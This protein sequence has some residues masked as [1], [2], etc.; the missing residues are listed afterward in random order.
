[1]TDSPQHPDASAA[2]AR[3]SWLRSLQ[4][5]FAVLLVLLAALAV[6]PWLVSSLARQSVDGLAR[7]FDRAGS[8][9]YRMRDIRRELNADNAARARA[10]VREQRA[11]LTALIEGEPTQGIPRC[12]AHELCERLVAHLGYL[13]NTLEPMTERALEDHSRVTPALESAIASQIKEID[14]TVAL[15]AEHMQ[16]RA[17]AIGGIG[18]A[19][20]S[21]ALVL[22]L[23]VGLGVWNVFGR[24]RRLRTA[25]I[26]KSEPEL[27]AEAKG[28]HELAVLA[29]SLADGLREMNARREADQR[30]LIELGDEQRALHSAAE[31]LSAWIA[32]SGSLEPALAGVAQATGLERLSFDEG[33]NSA[34]VD[35]DFLGERESIIPLTWHEEHLGVLRG[36]GDALTPEQRAVVDTFAQFL[37]LA[38]LSRRVLVEREHRGEVASDL[39]AISAFQPGP[40]RLGALIG[41]LVLHDDALLDVLDDAGRPVDRF[42]ITADALERVAT[43][44]AVEVPE[45]PALTS[46]GVL[47][48]GVCASSL[49][50]Q[51]VRLPLRVGGRLVGMLSLARCREL[52]SPHEYDALAALTPVLA[53]ALLRMHM[54]ERLRISEQWTTIGAFGRLLA[55]QLR[56]PLN[57]MKLTL[58][59]AHRRL[60]KLPQSSELD[61]LV[62]RM[63]ALT[64]EV[65]RID[66]RLTEYLAIHPAS[67]AENHVVVDFTAV[68][69]RALAELR[70]LASSASV[71]VVE[72]LASDALVI[73]NEAR[74]RQTV[75]Q[76][77]EN[78]VEALR[79]RPDPRLSV[80]LAPQGSS[81]ELVIRDNGP[82]IV[83]P[84]AIFAPGYTTKPSGTGMGLALGLHTVLQH[85]G[86]LSGRVPEGGGSEFTLSLPRHAAVEGTSAAE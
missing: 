67:G 21:G 68:V 7:T 6:T 41:K 70:E 56:N 27:R 61:G 44:A 62:E 2:P 30:R 83:D 12:P 3:P 20:G 4:A 8:L 46:G 60:R 25:I 22:V 11:T 38:C 24:V 43:P 57:S 15:T 9:R 14:R 78:A 19:A 63:S 33:S 76:L 42:R 18:T 59:V 74:L 80:S 55:D 34:T 86:H 1:M 28:S 81:W 50:G 53:S 17:T 71:E 73:G 52:F 29:Q 47:A 26:A 77:L 23:L 39:A 32:G 84:V 37:A 36:K 31:T 48:G 66:S 54:A 16:A 10:L 82:G 85:H 69:A 49:E 58:Q 13:V 64:D 79:G 35:A 45:S 75:G 40:S 51:V 72:A 5:R 65:E